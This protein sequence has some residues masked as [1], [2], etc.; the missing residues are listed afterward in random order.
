M[1]HVDQRGYLSGLAAAGAPGD[2]HHPMGVNRGK[3]DVHISGGQF[4]SGG[5]NRPLPGSTRRPEI[6]AN[7]EEERWK[8]GGVDGPRTARAIGRQYSRNS[9][10]VNGC[11]FKNA[12]SRRFCSASSS[13]ARD[14]R[15]F[16][17]AIR[18][19]EKSRR[20]TTV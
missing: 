9:C 12:L 10:F 11:L 1:K 13:I 16:T 19:E 20:V 17:V 15:A 2:E 5:I 8:T 4:D 14:S 7:S 6:P 18:F 3:R